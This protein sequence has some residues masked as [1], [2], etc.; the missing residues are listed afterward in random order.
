MV[1]EQS[2]G[3]GDEAASPPAPAAPEVQRDASEAQPAAPEGQP[4][5]ARSVT[6]ATAG[7]GPSA[8]PRSDREAAITAPPGGNAPTPY[9]M[10]WVPRPDPAG[11]LRYELRPAPPSGR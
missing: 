6:A 2:A 1:P 3:P 11:G 5:E 10:L 4:L 8:P 9:P 7:G